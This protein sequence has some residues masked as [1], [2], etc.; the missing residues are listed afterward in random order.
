METYARELKETLATRVSEL[1]RLTSKYIGYM[2]VSWS[3]CLVKV[4]EFRQIVVYKDKKIRK[5]KNN[6]L[7]NLPVTLSKQ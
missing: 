7:D 6:C 5:Q 4:K 3:R 1:E 2:R